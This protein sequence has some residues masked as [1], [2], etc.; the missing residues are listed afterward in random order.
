VGIA[1][2]IARRRIRRRKFQRLVR[3][4]SPQELPD[5][6]ATTPSQEVSD[7]LL[8][9]YRLLGRLPTNDRIAFTLRKIDGMS[10]AAIAEATGVSMATV[11]RRLTR[12]ERRFVMLASQHE[13]LRVWLKQ[14]TLER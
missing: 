11:K 8:L 9:T 12:A 2:H 5:C 7:A 13:T 1:V 3:F 10:M 4:V 6:A 14:G